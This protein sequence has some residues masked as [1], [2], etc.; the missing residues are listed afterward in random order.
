VSPKL[1]T[2]SGHPPKVGEEPSCK[3]IS[4]LAVC[5]YGWVRWHAGAGGMPEALVCEQ[6]GGSEADVLG[7][8]TTHS[9][10]AADPALLPGGCVAFS[11]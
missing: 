10:S 11:S 2:C 8:T 3:H 1:R 6:G 7:G 9:E 5:L 4:C